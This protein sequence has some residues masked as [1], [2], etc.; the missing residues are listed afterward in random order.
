MGFRPKEEYEFATDK[1]NCVYD[2]RVSGLKQAQEGESLEVQEA[3]VRRLAEAK[4]WHIVRGWVITKSGRKKSRDYFLEILQF[5]DDHPKTIQYYLFRSIDRFTRAG[6]ADYEW[7]KSE[8]ARRG[9]QILDTNGVIQPSRNSLEE[10]GIEYEWSRTS[11]SAVAEIVLAHTAGDEVHNILTRMIGQEIRLT[12]DGYRTRCPVDGYVNEKIFIEGTGK[13][14]T[15]QVPDPKRAPYFRAMFDL[16]AR[17]LADEE[18]VVQV[19]ALGY[20]T[21]LR[22]RWNKDLT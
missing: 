10:L 20:R 6:S 21:P 3:A 4:G 5:I 12:Q 8:L 18:I 7:M 22:N 1:P 19:N 16:R 15:I 11:P 13:K 9:V 17:G 14:K 2:C